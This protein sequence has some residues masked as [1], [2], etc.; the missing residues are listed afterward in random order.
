M[1]EMLLQKETDNNCVPNFPDDLM[2]RVCGVLP[3][4][5]RDEIFRLLQALRGSFAREITWAEGLEAERSLL[6]K[7]AALA[8]ESSTL[9]SIHDDLNA[10]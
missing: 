2:E 6:L 10:R 8:T 5:E 3:L 1:I 4:L 7:R 9:L